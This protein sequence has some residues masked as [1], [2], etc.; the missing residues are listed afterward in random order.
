MITS[1]PEAVLETSIRAAP[2]V[3]E[4]QTD[5]FLG[6]L[7][8]RYSGLGF[9]TRILDLGCG[10][11]DIVRELQKRGYAAWGSDLDLPAEQRVNPTYLETDPHTFKVASK[12][13][14]FDIIISNQVLE[15]VMDHE[16]MFREIRR[17]LR[18]GG[19][20]LHFFPSRWSLLEQHVLVPLAGVIRSRPYL[21]FWAALGIRNGFQTNK[22]AREVSELNFEYLRDH[23]NYPP[24][25]YYSKPLQNLFHDFDFIEE[26]FLNLLLSQTRRGGWKFKILKFLLILKLGILYR[27][28]RGR[29]L[30]IQG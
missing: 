26:E 6:I 25:T 29:V 15:H 5:L 1:D 8:N 7:K 12:D 23:T 9:E 28:F 18:P 21:R 10:R 4:R 14:S 3:Y 22:S 30:W 24:T 16:K 11:G 13:G 19:V 27:I 17:L 2:E 20:S